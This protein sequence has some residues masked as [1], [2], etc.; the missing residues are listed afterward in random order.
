M[1]SAVGKIKRKAMREPYWAT[2]DTRVA[3]S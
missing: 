1:R 2:H 3:G